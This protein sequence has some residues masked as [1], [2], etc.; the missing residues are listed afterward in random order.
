[1]NAFRLL[2]DE[3]KVVI[4]VMPEKRFSE[5]RSF[6]DWADFMVNYDRTLKQKVMEKAT[7]EA[8]ENKS[9]SQR[10]LAL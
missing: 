10:R 7:L 2:T 1:M 9:W 5:L 8:N 6:N 3:K 4:Y